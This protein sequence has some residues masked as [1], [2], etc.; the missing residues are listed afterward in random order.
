MIPDKLSKTLQK[1][2]EELETITLLEQLQFKRS[3]LKT[4]I[5]HIPAGSIAHAIAVGLENARL[6]EAEVQAQKQARYQLDISNL[7]LRAANTLTS[8]IDLDE[9]L[10]RLA[11]IALEATGRSRAFVNLIDMN[12]R[13]LTPKVAT[14]GLKGLSGPVFSFVQLSKTSVEA[15]L[16]KKTVV[17]DY[18]LPE[19]PE[20]D[21]KIAQANNS[22]LVL[23]VPLLLKDE[24]IG[25]ITLDEPGKRHQFTER[26]IKIVE[27]IAAQAAV[28]IENGRLFEAQH[29]MAETLKAVVEN[30]N[31]LIVYLDP[32]MNFIMANDAYV[33]GC[34][35]S[36][37][38]LIGHNHFDLFPNEENEAIFK[39]ARDTGEPVEY[40]AKPFEYSDQPW[41]GVTYW[42]WR[43]VPVKDATGLVI[44]LV[45]T[46]V[47]VTE[48]ICSKQLSDSLNNINTLISS[49]LDHSEIKKVAVVEAGKAIRCESAAIM[50]YEKGR[51]AVKYLYGNPPELLKT[52]FTD[53]EA[54]S[55]FVAGKTKQP[56][57][58][59]NTYNDDRVNQEVMNRYGI[60]SLL[61]SPLVIKGEIIGCL[62]FI[63]RTEPVA[64]TNQQIDFAK[65]LAASLSLALENARLFESE[66]KTAQKLV[67]NQKNLEKL[68]K[69]RTEELE[70]VNSL[71]IDEIDIRKKT[72]KALRLSE[73]QHRQIVEASPDA[74][75]VFAQNK[76]LYA[77]LAALHLFGCK[78]TEEI[79]TSTLKHLIMPE[80]YKEI[81]KLKGSQKP[82]HLGEITIG[83]EAFLP[84][85]VEVSVIPVVFEGE[86][87]SQYIVRDITQRKEMEKE[88][89]RLDRLHLIGEM[90]AGIGHEV[91]NP[92]TSVRGFLQLLAN[93]EPDP[94]KLEYYDIM[95]EELDRANSIITE[96]LS[97]AKDRAVKL[98]PTSLNIIINSLYPLLSTDAI[99][100]DKRIKLQKS[101][102]PNVP[103]NEKEIRQLIINLVKNGLDAMSSG[104]VLTIGTFTENDEVVLFIEDEGTGIKPEIYDKLGTP[105][106]TTKCHGTGLGLS[107]CYSIA[108][109]HNAKIDFKTG[110]AG[111]TFF[112]RF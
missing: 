50:M 108:D 64:F 11:K 99:N 55:S 71:L 4:I 52:T 51:W 112:V 23:F 7:L 103:L 109:K 47:D 57:I 98:K 94:K 62:L 75:F 73:A 8:A 18:E 90:A 25:H 85:T 106:V 65:K 61:S 21:R 31:A 6:Y 36:R 101:D 34:G 79:D 10:A 28:A 49:T 39:R 104:G 81:E 70:N 107:V 9:V 102:I 22:R 60:R 111:T 20:H 76:I 105:F 66:R 92:M 16:A 44:G 78:K 32:D 13:E 54:E 77:N 38:E 86:N 1:Q 24:I 43:L 72:E 26:E 67:E 41:R 33:S 59:N 48:T 2:N 93:K 74:Y 56:V 30:T 97:L 17:L 14:G 40:K 12:R 3:Q 82:V 87:A 95:V 69:R 42:D 110:S 88:M 45:L 19:T 100:Q 37:D 53:E 46:L 68:V 27:G 83:K 96:F 58:I 80:K 89:A 84:T 5:G 63:Y 91:R 29:S 35:H 15:I